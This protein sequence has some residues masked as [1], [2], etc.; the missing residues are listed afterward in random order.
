MKEGTGIPKGERV[1]TGYYNR[2]GELLF[3]ITSKEARD[4]YF[5][6]EREGEG[7]KKLGKAKSPPELEK[8]FHVKEKMR[9]K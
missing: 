6:Y 4:W 8:K 1:W 9:A 2:K 7:F 5:L 3:V